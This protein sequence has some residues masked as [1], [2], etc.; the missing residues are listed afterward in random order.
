MG[1]KKLLFCLF[2]NPNAED[3]FLMSETKQLTQFIGSINTEVDVIWG[4]RYDES[5]GNQVKSQS[6]QPD[7]TSLCVV[8]KTR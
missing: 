6:S 3:K 5:L 7:L 2:F 8:R 4:V 1:S